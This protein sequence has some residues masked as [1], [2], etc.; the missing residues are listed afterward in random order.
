MVEG[1][2]LGGY[3]AAG[4]RHRVAATDPAPVGSV[5]AAGRPPR[6]G[7]GRRRRWPGARATDPGPRPGRACP[8]TQEPGLDGR[9]GVELAAGRRAAL[10]R[11]GTSS[12]CRPRG[13]AACSRSAPGSADARRGSCCCE[14]TPARDQAG[15]RAGRAGRQGHHLRHRRA[16]DQAPRVDGADEDRHG[17]RGRGARRG[18]GLRRR[19]GPAPRDRAA[20][21]GRER[22]RRRRPTG[23]AT[24]CAL[25]AAGPSRS[26]TPTRRAGWCWPTRW[27]TPT[28]G[29]TREVLVDV[30]TLTGA[31]TLGLGPPARGAV[32]HRR[33][34]W[35]P[36][37][38]PPRRRQRRGGLADAAG[39]GLPRRA[40]L[41]RRRPAARPRRTARVG[42][43]SITAALFLREFTGGRRWAHLDIA[44]P[45]RA[46]KDEYEVTRGATGFGARLLLRW[47]EALR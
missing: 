24:W 23:P 41:R 14:H 17:R 6:R 46:D 29:S 44:G 19:R 22:G 21:A 8:R 45:A 30:A 4:H 1:L 16:V 5:T 43:G 26:P 35:P 38:W 11:S 37:W 47:L 39:R 10:P 2:L 20:A 42:G 15:R 36:R 28:P 31:A 12:G 27:P 25:P 9:A 40:R 3:G 34:G 33:R 13:S 7:R 18:R 32:R